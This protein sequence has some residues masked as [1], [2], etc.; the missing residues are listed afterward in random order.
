MRVPAVNYAYSNLLHG[1]EEVVERQLSNL[2]EAAP[3]P[4]ST[5][6]LW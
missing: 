5:P 1:M 3:A 6:K 4:A 2:A